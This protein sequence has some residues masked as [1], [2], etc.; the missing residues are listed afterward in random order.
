MK[1]VF[2]FLV[3]RIVSGLRYIIKRIKDDSCGF[4]DVRRIIPLLMRPNGAKH[5]VFDHVSKANDRAQRGANFM[6]EGSYQI[7]VR[8][9]HICTIIGDIFRYDVRRTLLSPVCLILILNGIRVSST[10]LCRPLNPPSLTLKRKAL[11]I[12]GNPQFHSKLG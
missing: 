9:W 8:L 1:I 11:T 3:M 12:T 6:R 2:C 4:V 10:H 7:E 5:L